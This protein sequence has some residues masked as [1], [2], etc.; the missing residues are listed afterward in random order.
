MEEDETGQVQKLP[1][2][3]RLETLEERLQRVQ[4]NEAIRTKKV[5]TT[6]VNERLGGQV[7]SYL[8]GGLLGGALIGWVLD[9]MLGTGHL[10]LIVMLV[11]GTLGG[12]WSIV[13]LANRRP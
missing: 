7:L 5:Q 1:E 9:K 2:D 6:D 10:L 8:I 12:M 11:L 13:K 4:A 3:A